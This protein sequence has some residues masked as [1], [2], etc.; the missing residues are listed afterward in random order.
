MYKVKNTKKYKTRTFRKL[1]TA[2]LVVV[3]V[4]GAVAGTYAYTR[5]S[6]S[7]ESQTDVT[8]VIGGPTVEEASAGDKQKEGIEKA[9]T[10]AEGDSKATIDQNSPESSGQADV[11]I[12]DATQYN[13]D[14]EVRAFVSNIIENGNCTITVTKDS[15]KI[16]RTVPATADATTTQ[17][18]SLLLKTSDFPSI[19][20]WTVIVK[21]TSTNA[22]GEA[23]ASLEIT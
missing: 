5:T 15:Y 21:F 6:D 2:L 7:N 18:Q 8:T 20:T 17:C 14:V 22:T 12:V 23:T 16:E 4:L 1:F 19:G 13:I 3:V 11:V 10:R 9:S